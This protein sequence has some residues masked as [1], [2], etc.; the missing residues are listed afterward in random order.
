MPRFDQILC[1][2]QINIKKFKKLRLHVNLYQRL[3]SKPVN[4]SKGLYSCLMGIRYC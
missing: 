3:N 2:L 1:I 4:S